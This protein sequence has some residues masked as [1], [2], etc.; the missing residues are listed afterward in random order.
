MHERICNHIDHPS[1]WTAESV[2]GKT[3]F[4]L[5]LD[6]QYLPTFRAAIDEVRRRGLDVEKTTLADFKLPG[7]DVVLAELKHRLDHKKGLVILRGFPVGDWESKDIEY[8]YWAVGLHLGTAVNQSVLGDRLGHVVDVTDIDS[9][10]RA[11]RSQRELSLHND[12]GNYHG[13]LCIGKPKSGGASRYASSVAIHNIMRD[14]APEHLERLYQGFSLYR[15]GE[16]GPNE[17]PYTPHQ[18]PVFSCRDDYLSSRYMRGF[19]E[20]GAT[21]RG[22]PLTTSDVAAMDC[23]DEI[24]HRDEVMMQFSLELGEAAFYNNLFVMHAR[25]AF[26]D[27][28]PNG[29]RRHLLRLWLYTDNGRPIVPEIELFDYPGIMYQPGKTPSGEGD[30][31]RRL[32]AKGFSKARLVADND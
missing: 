9:N 20:A 2:T 30:L 12:M 26:E 5:D 18:V 28:K 14:E 24:A 22:Q 23:L 1:A 13:M 7:V 17:L 10:A 3:S 15:L 31:L 19:I 4:V 11:Y 25:E 29:I 8:M 32:G 16:E 21:L 6:C 27:D